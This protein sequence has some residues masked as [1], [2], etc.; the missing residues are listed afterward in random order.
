MAR[1][2]PTPNPLIETRFSVRWQRTYTL[3]A[4]KNGTCEVWLGDK[5]VHK[6]ADPAFG[7]GI[8][9]KRWP[10]NKLQAEAMDSA[11]IWIESTVAPD[12]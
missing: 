1:E 11:R 4:F 9:G 2:A 12:G 10:S 6:M 5:L 3:K 7:I 8:A